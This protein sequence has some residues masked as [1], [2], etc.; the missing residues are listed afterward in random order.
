MKEKK[1]KK[2]RKKKKITSTK[3]ICLRS[4]FALARAPLMAGTGPIPMIF[5]STPADCQE[6][7]RASGVNPCFF[8]AS[9]FYQKI[10]KNS[11]IKRY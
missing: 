9:Y 8:T 5:G 7:M 11:F 1:E 10:L 3:S 2:R 4:N 6:T